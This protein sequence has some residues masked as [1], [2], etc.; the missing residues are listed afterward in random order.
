[1]TPSIEWK[2]GLTKRKGPKFYRRWNDGWIS[3]YYFPSK[4][5]WI[6]HNKT[7]I[8]DH[9][10]HFSSEEQMKADVIKYM[11]DHVEEENVKIYDAITV[12]EYTI[13]E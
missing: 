8:K 7:A 1:M 9:N 12:T 6:M 3:T 5:I 2:K 11:N 10:L 13:V 4:H